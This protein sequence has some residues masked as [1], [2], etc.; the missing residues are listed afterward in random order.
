MRGRGSADTW[1]MDEEENEALG[2]DDGVMAKKRPRPPKGPPPAKLLRTQGWRPRESWKS[3]K[4][5]DDQNPWE[6][7]YQRREHA[8]QRG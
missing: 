6:G 8:S 5:H 7:D 1:G 4:D 2:R 3:Q